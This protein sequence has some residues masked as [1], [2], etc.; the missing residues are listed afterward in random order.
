VPG[1]IEVGG[2]IE[3]C[4]TAVVFEQLGGFGLTNFGAWINLADATFVAADYGQ[5]GGQPVAEECQ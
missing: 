1:G 3:A 4:Q 5:P 2:V